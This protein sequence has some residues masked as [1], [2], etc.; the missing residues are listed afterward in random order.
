MG[1]ST[2]ASCTADEQAT[3]VGMDPADLGKKANDCGTGAYNVL[4]G[5]FNHDKFNTCFTGKVSI[6][7]LALSA[8]LPLVSTAPRTA[9]HHACSAGASRAASTALPLLR[10]LLVTAWVPQP[11]TAQPCNDAVV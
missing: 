11:G 8:M 5:N 7:T 6:S 10:R 1:E 4:T 2:T 3:L 9:R